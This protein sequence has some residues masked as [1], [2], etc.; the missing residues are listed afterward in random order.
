MTVHQCLTISMI[1]PEKK[2]GREAASAHVECPSLYMYV[3]VCGFNGSHIRV[4]SSQA[5]VFG[6]T[7]RPTSIIQNTFIVEHLIL[8]SDDVKLCTGVLPT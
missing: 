2:H 3:T 1:Q 7:F 4:W 6:E 5:R 8:T